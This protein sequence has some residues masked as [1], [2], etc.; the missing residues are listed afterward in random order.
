ME[1][2]EGKNSIY[3]AL[4]AKIGI[5]KIYILNT[6]KDSKINQI[7]ELAKEQKVVIKFVDKNFL[8]NISQTK[9][10]KGIIAESADY[11]YC[12]VEDILFYA[13]SKNEKPFI[14]I[15]DEI[16][17]PHNVGA[18]IR[19]ANACKVHGIII[20]NRNACQITPT[21]VASSSGATNY[22]RI[23]KVVNITKTIEE[24]KKQNIWIYC[25]DMDGD[26]IYKTKFDS[27]TCIVIGNEGSG[28]SQLVKQNS[29]FNISIP[30]L[31]EINSLNASVAASVIMY[32][33]VRQNF[34][35]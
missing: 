22:M 29:D 10:H 18:I 1:Y 32:E 17:D 35:K 13:K 27:A 28:V 7:I 3:E 11:K 4:N 31:G 19:T 5:N 8:D 16:M 12:E 25:A 24:L 2:L 21:V 6:I 34:I 14:I 23:A 30:M 26:S 15:L 33:V 9:N 20:K